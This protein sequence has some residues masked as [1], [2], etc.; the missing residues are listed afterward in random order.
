MAERFSWERYIL[1]K[2]K[3]F[4]SAEAFAKWCADAR[5]FAYTP[6]R[7]RAVREHYA[8]CKVEDR[9][10]ARMM[11]AEHFSLSIDSVEGII[12]RRNDRTEKK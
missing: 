5:L 8:R 1:S 7:N 11:T 10:L 9:L 2:A 3:E 6:V 4:E 12:Y